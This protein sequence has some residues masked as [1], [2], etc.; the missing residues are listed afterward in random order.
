MSYEVQ[1]NVMVQP[2][3]APHTT[4]QHKAKTK[5]KTQKQKQKQKPTQ[6][7]EFSQDL[8][9]MKRPEHLWPEGPQ[10]MLPSDVLTDSFEKASHMMSMDHGAS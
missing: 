4:V 9:L 7:S 5:P 1:C 8:A 2:L 3:V 10:K 6:I